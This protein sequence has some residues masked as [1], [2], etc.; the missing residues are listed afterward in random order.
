MALSLSISSKLIKG[1]DNSLLR[2][3][4]ATTIFD[5]ETA[6]LF[7]WAKV[8][9]QLSGPGFWAAIFF[10]AVLLIGFVYEWKQGALEWQ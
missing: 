4:V 7:P 2:T 1:I 6:F 8:I 5:L 9:R 10:L 3:E